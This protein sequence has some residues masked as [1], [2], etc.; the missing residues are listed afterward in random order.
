MVPVELMYD[1]K[2]WGGNWLRKAVIIRGEDELERV[3]GIIDGNPLE[4]ALISAREV[5][6]V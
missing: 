2:T 5:K 1:H 4:Y 3:M 6:N